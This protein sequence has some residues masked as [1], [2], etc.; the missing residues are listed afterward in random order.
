MRGG[1]AEER[2]VRFAKPQVGR[3]AEDAARPVPTRAIGLRAA[4][5]AA[6]VLAC[7]GCGERTPDVSKTPAGIPHAAQDDRSERTLDVSKTQN[8]D[9]LVYELDSQT[10]FSGKVV[11]AWPNGRK[12]SETT[13][14]DGKRDGLLVVWYE[15]GQKKGEGTNK[16]G[17]LQGLAT[18]WYENGQKKVEGNYRDGKLEGLFTEWHE[19][20][21]KKSETPYRDGNIVAATPERDSASSQ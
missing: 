21:E 2:V 3:S 14:K 5:V 18:T 12:K 15:S 10:P 17:K 13:Y 7:A 1:I 20:G 16:D 6:T 4:A 19:N 11:E 8:R 9:G